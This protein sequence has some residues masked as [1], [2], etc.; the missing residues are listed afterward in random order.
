MMMKNLDLRL[1]QANVYTLPDR[2][3]QA[4][5][6]A[7]LKG[8]FEPG[9]RIV[10]EEIANS[11]GV[12]RMPVREALRKLEAEGLIQIEPNRGAVVKPLSLEDIEEIYLLRSV[13]EKM[14][15][16]ESLKKIQKQDIVEMESLVTIMDQVDEVDYFISTNIEFHRLLMKHCT[17]KRLLSFI[18]TLWNGFPQQ[19][20]HLLENQMKKSNQE[21][22]EILEAVKENEVQ[23]AAELVSNHVQ[24]TGDALVRY[25]KNDL[26]DKNKEFI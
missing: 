26:K 10:Q 13:L 2:V 3:C 24:R 25:I 14:A 18:N 1:D 16:E 19:T 20:P 7:I 15:V 5:R 11:L 8:K 17:K 22:R 9:E 21:H 23:K 6:E 4:L 12:S